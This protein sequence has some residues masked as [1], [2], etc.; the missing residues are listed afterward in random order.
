MLDQRSSSAWT[1]NRLSSASFRHPWPHS[2]W[3]RQNLRSVKINAY[4]CTVS[5]SESHHSAGSH[6][7]YRAIRGIRWLELA[8]EGGVGSQCRR[9]GDQ[10]ISRAKRGHD[11]WLRRS[12]FRSITGWTVRRIQMCKF[13]AMRIPSVQFRNVYT[14]R[15]RIES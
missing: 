1:T 9:S 10:L 5:L 12:T 4:M 11:R 14:A 15:H 3:L 6:A 2:Q 8:S 7:D 13:H